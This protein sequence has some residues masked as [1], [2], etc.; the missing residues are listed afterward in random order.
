MKTKN[1]HLNSFNPHIATCKSIENKIN[2]PTL[3]I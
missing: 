1:T 3:K 2:D